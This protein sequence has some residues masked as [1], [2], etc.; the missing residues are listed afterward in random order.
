MLT[1][2][3]AESAEEDNQPTSTSMYDTI[4]PLS[5]A[6]GTVEGHIYDVLNRSQAT[7]LY[8]HVFILGLHRIGIYIA[9]YKVMS[10]MAQYLYLSYMHAW[11][12][13]I[14]V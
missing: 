8:I 2:S 4:Q 10:K 7:G 3:T 13:Y 9:I 11:D 1:S 12:Q 14:H 6:A 5:Q